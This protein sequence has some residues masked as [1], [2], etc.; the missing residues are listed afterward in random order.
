MLVATRELR[1][2]ILPLRAAPKRLQ[3]ALRFLLRLG[4]RLRWLWLLVFFPPGPLLLRLALLGCHCLGIALGHKRYCVTHG[5]SR[6][7]AA[8][9]TQRRRSCGFRSLRVVVSSESSEK[10]HALRHESLEI[11]PSV[12]SLRLKF[13]RCVALPPIWQATKRL[14]LRGRVQKPELPDKSLG[15]CSRE[16]RG[17]RSWCATSRIAGIGRP[18]DWSRRLSHLP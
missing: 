2:P 17:R 10:C 18:G 15:L 3:A 5:V 9:A 16:V 7:G 8:G 1:R 6:E 11:F 4:R 14:L 12:L 13:A